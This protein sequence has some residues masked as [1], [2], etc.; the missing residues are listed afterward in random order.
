M[1]KLEIQYVLVAS[2]TLDPRIPRLA[3]ASYP[4]S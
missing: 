3:P 4:H 2:I 1:I